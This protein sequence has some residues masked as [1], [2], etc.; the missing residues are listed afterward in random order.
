MIALPVITASTRRQHGVDLHWNHS[1]RSTQ[2]WNRIRIRSRAPLSG[3]SLDFLHL[4]MRRRAEY[5][6]QWWRRWWKQDNPSAKVKACGPAM[7]RLLFLKLN[8]VASGGFCVSLIGNCSHAVRALESSSLLDNLKMC[9]VV[10][11]M[12]HRQNTTFVR[13][14]WVFYL[15]SSVNLIRNVF[16]FLFILFYFIF[17]QKT[18]SEWNSLCYLLWRRPT[19]SLHCGILTMKPSSN[20]G[21]NQNP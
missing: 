3:F 9:R 16:F 2:L 19:W 11:A 5:W 4:W 7:W 14:L 12:K 1:Q 15:R 6:L 8:Y 10:L 21:N 18:T 20:Q 17:L 13:A